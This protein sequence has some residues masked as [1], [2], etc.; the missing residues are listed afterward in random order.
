M[1][2]KQPVG[3]RRPGPGVIA[4]LLGAVALGGLT[5]TVGYGFA[6][7][8]GDTGAPALEVA[9]RTVQSWS[10]GV[11]LTAAVA[12]GAALSARGSRPVA[13]AAAAVV[14]GTALGLAAG[15]VLG[16]EAKYA[17]YPTVP[18]CTDEF[19]GGPAMPV[20]RAA[21]RELEGLHHPAPFSGGGSS[22]V[23]GCSSE[24]MM[25]DGEDPGPH[26][27]TALPD[28][29]W[30]VVTDTD[31]VLVAEKA[32]QAFELALDDVGSWTVW[33]GPKGR[34]APDLEEGQAGPRR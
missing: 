26:Y 13:L 33:V 5:V 16:T 8:Y 32:D 28:A 18:N 34:S 2:E 6:T 30:T 19:D 9:W 4:A 25:R 10:I 27:R 7:E 21:Q 11:G 3:A 20:T 22:G 15:G 14:A 31:E 24:L 17:R 1:D 23:D 29:G 12:V